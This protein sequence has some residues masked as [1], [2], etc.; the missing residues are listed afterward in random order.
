M[1]NFQSEHLGFWC[2]L[3]GAMIS[4]V[5]TPTIIVLLAWIDI[6]F[7]SPDEISGG[8]IRAV[9]AMI[10]MY[11]ILVLIH[12]IFFL[13]CYYFTALPKKIFEKNRVF[14]ILGILCLCYFLTFLFLQF[15]NIAQLDLEA[16]AM[17]FIP[18]LLMIIPMMIAILLRDSIVLFCLKRK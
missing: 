18:F 17:L 16:I 15:Q 2:W 13:I 14:K 6:G 9:G 11:P 8:Y 5:I 1:R 10:M 12:I 4:G 3:V 7:S